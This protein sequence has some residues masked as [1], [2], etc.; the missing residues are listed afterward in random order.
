MYLFSKNRICQTEENIL[1]NLTTRKNH[2]LCF[3]LM[4]CMWWCMSFNTQVSVCIY[5]CVS[6]IIFTKMVL[7][8]LFIKPNFVFILHIFISGILI[9]AN[10]FS[11][12][13][14]PLFG[15]DLS[16]KFPYVGLSFFNFNFSPLLKKVSGNIF[17]LNLCT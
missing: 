6:I 15:N 5:L 16:T 1:C 12:T 3:A 8:F 17:W 2:H 10:I 4:N 9:Y 7:Y 11:H 13:I 14:F